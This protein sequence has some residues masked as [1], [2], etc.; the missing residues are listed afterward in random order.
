[1]RYAELHC[2]SNFSFLRGA[3]HPD[4]LVRTAKAL[5]Y[6]AIAIT[7]HAT[8]AGIVRAHAAAKQA[9]I[10]LV[11]GAALEPVDAAP[12]VVWAIDRT[13]Y[14]HLCRLLTRGY[15]RG[16]LSRDDIACHAGGLLAGVPLAACLAAGPPGGCGDGQEIGEQVLAWRQVFDDR[17]HALAEVALEGDDED[18]L[19]WFARIG[20]LANV[21]LVAAGDVRYHERSRLP[22]FDALSAVRHGGTI[23]E[24]RG[25]LLANGERHLHERWRI[26][27][28]FAAFPDAVE[29]SVEIAERCMFSLDE[30]RYEYPDAT[31]PAGRSPQEHLAH[32]AWTGAAKRYPD[33]I[34]DAVRRLVEHELALIAEL[35]YEAYFLT[36]FDIVRFARR[37]GILCQGRGSA[38][39]SAVC[40]CLGITSVDPARMN[41]LF[42]RFVSRERRE[43]PDIDIDFEH[44]RRE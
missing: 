29:R 43:A 2:T 26:V 32:V 22:L 9:G 6:E 23:E 8:L 13:G 31:V 42:E 12:L 39:N 4:E 14:G 10:K 36:V 34:P 25:R 19:R 24:I 15:E 21:P 11:V 3:S 28:R 38:A 1:M 33:G 41:V 17:L 7:D 30:L 44:A 35:G 37:R 18:R 27:E 20:R 40:Y 5:E 16:R